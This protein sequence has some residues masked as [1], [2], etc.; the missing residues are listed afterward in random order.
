MQSVTPYYTVSQSSLF[1]ILKELAKGKQ[2]VNLRKTN[3]LTI[4]SYPSLNIRFMVAI[5]PLMLAVILLVLMELPNNPK[6]PSAWPDY[7]FG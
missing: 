2:T 3:T 7:R 6:A 5:R 1:K 4:I